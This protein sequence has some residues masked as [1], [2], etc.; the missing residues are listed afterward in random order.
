MNLQGG[1]ADRAAV[2]SAGLLTCC[3]CSM[4]VLTGV[5]QFFSAGLSSSC[6]LAG[7]VFMVREVVQKCKPK[8]VTCFQTSAQAPWEPQQ[9]T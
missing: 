9:V 4:L 3:G 1:Y 7:H 2:G 6:R 8:H 5:T